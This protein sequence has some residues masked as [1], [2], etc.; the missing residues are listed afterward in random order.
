MWLVWGTYS[1]TAGTSGTDGASRTSRTLGRAEN[2]RS[3]SGEAELELQAEHFPWPI[4][5]PLWSSL[6]TPR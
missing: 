1:R 3:S 4:Y 6:L 5:L 2:I